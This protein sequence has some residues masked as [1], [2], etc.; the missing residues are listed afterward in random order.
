LKADIDALDCTGSSPLFLA[1]T[2]YLLTTEKS[3]GKPTTEQAEDL[4]KLG[5]TIRFLRERGANM[6]ART[7]SGL[8]PQM[9]LDTIHG[10]P[11]KIPPGTIIVEDPPSSSHRH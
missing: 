1:L 3:A 8:T 6:Q 11:I 9:M 10:V 2:Y 5:D 4:R 7:K